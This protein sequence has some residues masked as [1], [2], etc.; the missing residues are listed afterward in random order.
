MN[1]IRDVSNVPSYK[2]DELCRTCHALQPTRSQPSASLPLTWLLRHLSLG[3]GR[4]PSR[5]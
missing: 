5:C 1:F 3:R 4:L 2:M